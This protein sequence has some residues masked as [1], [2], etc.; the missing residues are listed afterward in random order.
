MDDVQSKYSDGAKIRER[1][2]G[3]QAAYQRQ[4]RH[5]RRRCSDINCA[6]P[7]PGKDR[8]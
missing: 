4:I 2:F 7:Q 6:L 3:S 5:I 8:D 1:R